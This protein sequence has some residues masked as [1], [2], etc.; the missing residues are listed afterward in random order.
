MNVY[1]IGWSGGDREGTIFVRLDCSSIYSSSRLFP[2]FLQTVGHSMELL[3]DYF[4]I[5][6]LDCHLQLG[7]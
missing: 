2:F 7:S 5:F 6:Y 4:L 3:V 1:C